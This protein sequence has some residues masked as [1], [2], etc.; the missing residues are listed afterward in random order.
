MP[1]EDKFETDWQ[2]KTNAK[3]EEEEIEAQVNLNPNN[4]YP[5]VLNEEP[6]FDLDCVYAEIDCEI[7]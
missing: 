1:H 7:N 2:S 4:L 6:D 3:A 5:N